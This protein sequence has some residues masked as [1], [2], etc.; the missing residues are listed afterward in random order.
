MYDWH[1][2]GEIAIALFLLADPVGA[3]PI[4]LA[5][6]SD[7]TKEEKRHTA[8]L[9]AGTV[10]T[11]LIAFVFVGVPL[12]QIFGIRIA[13]F[14]VG[15]GVLILMMAI[16]MMFAPPV[17]LIS[18]ETVEAA[19]KHDLAIVPLGVPLIAGPGVVS[20]VIVYSQ[21]ARDA[22]EK[23]FL[24]III[25][26]LATF[27]WVAL[28]LA[29]PIS[30]LLGRNGINLVVRLMGLLLAAIAVEFITGGLTELLPGLAARC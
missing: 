26:L 15:G 16:S 24:V 27:I 20:S 22:Y 4:F 23:A 17:P 3:I 9:A 28:W 1:K 5:L 10:A 2:Y 14:R 29:Q 11:V 30:R 19:G 8:V 25:A 7:Q 13:S 21:Q 6:T 12:L 18:K